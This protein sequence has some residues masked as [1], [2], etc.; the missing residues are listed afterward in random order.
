MQITLD[1]PKGD[2]AG[3]L[4]HV[5]NFFDPVAEKPTASEEKP[6]WPDGWPAKD[7]V[8]AGADPAVMFRDRLSPLAR[9]VYTH[10]VTHP[11]ERFDAD[12]IAETF[13]VPN[14][15]SGV[16]GLWAWPSRHAAAVGLPEAPWCWHNDGL[17]THYWVTPDQAELV[18]HAFVS[19]N[20]DS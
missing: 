14:G 1:V 15:R 9:T 12:W 18:G 19:G 13:S 4:R 3:F 6:V 10:L 17:Q 8:F 7:T 11:G 5:A 20:G 16:A 2:E